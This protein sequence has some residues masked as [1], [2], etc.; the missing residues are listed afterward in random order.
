MPV[1]A[2]PW[3]GFCVPWLIYAAGML[4]LNPIVSGTL[5]GAMLGPLAPPAAIDGIGFAILAGWSMTVAGTPYSAN[6]MLLHRITGYDPHVAAFSWNLRLSM[7]TL[8]VA[9]LLAAVLTQH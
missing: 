3:V 5:V 1:A 9:G 6:A 7:T 2:W 4:G 8:T